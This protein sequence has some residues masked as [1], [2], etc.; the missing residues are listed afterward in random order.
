MKSYR[1]KERMRGRQKNTDTE[2]LE[3]QRN[4]R[5]ETNTPTQ[6][7]KAKHIREINVE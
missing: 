2:R 5:N 3:R 6:R 7:E 4:E 1:K